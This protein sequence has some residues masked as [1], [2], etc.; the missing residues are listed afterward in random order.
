MVRW[1]LIGII[2]VVMLVV[3][4]VVMGVS[5]GMVLVMMVIVAIVG[6]DLMVVVTVMTRVNQKEVFSS[7]QPKAGRR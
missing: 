1:M 3:M 5:L 7:V 4:M 2:M 6:G